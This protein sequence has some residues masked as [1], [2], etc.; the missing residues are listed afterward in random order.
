MKYQHEFAMHLSY[1]LDLGKALT[2]AIEF[3]LIYGVP[4]GNVQTSLLF[5]QELS[6]V[7]KLAVSTSDFACSQQIVKNL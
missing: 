1:A 7:P 3:Q 4:T 6:A 5:V 2:F